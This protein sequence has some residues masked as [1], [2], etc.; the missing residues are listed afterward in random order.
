MKLGILFDLDGTLLNTLEDLKDATNYALAQ[1]GCPPRTL[2][3]VRMAV[4]NGAERLIRLSLPGKADD[5]DV[6]EVL[7]TYQKYYAAHSQIKTCPYPGI[8]EALAELKKHYPIAIVSN[9]PDIAVKPLCRDYFGADIF[10]LGET[11]DCPRKP[12]PDMVNKAMDTIGV[13]TC[14]YVGDS[15]VDVVTARNAGV[16]CL[17]VLWGFRDRDCMEQVGGNHFCD[18]PGKLADKLLEMAQAICC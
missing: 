5:P 8:L 18:D 12:A 2:E 9:K 11:A 14:I 17:S 10:A 3:Q 16:P 13:D 4:G 7:A 15:D 1:Y 6:K